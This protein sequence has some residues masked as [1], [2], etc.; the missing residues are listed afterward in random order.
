MFGKMLGVRLPVHDVAQNPLA[1]S[2]GDVG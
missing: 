1:G 2:A